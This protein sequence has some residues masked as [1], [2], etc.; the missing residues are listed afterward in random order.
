M[1]NLDEV[2]EGR[3]FNRPTGDT[4]FA[5]L[6]GHPHVPSAGWLDLF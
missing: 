6:G 2:A 3:T 5:S 1:E 4:I